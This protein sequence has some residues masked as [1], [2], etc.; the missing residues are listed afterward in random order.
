[1]NSVI[2][3]GIWNNQYC[4]GVLHVT[5][6]YLFFIEA[7]QMK[8]FFKPL[9]SF[10]DIKIQQEDSFLDGILLLTNHHNVCIKKKVYT[11][12]FCCF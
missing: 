9:T 6:N 8:Q 1:M 7:I 10:Q 11:C 12:I 4:N 5:Q 2:T 3:C